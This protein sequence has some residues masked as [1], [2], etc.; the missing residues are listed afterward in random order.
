MLLSKEQRVIYPER[1]TN[2]EQ[3]QNA[4]I[5]EAYFFDTGYEARYYLPKSSLY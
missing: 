4:L 2:E 3:N 1:S 5:Y